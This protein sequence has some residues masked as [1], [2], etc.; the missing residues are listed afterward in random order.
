MITTVVPARIT[1]HGVERPS[2]TGKSE[3]EI[4]SVY[5]SAL[6]K[7]SIGQKKSFQ[8]ATI[9]NEAHEIKA[10]PMTGNIILLKI[11]KCC[12]LIY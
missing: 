8:R 2:E 1:G 5:F 12:F 9:V 10:G 4:I 11:H 7:K 3:I 6:R